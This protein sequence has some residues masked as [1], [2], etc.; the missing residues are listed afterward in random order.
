MSWVT[1]GLGAG[2]GG[3]TPGGTTV[4]ERVTVRVRPDEASARSREDVVRVQAK[5]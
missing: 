1:L 3:T 5:G 2:A 4:V